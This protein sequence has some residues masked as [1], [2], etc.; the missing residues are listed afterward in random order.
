MG[1]SRAGRHLL[2]TPHAPDHYLRDQ[3]AC[4][5]EIRGNLSRAARGGLPPRNTVRSR[6]WEWRRSL[7]TFV[8][9]QAPRLSR[10]LVGIRTYLLVDCTICSVNHHFGC[11]FRSAKFFGGFN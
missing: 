11:A 9:V 1:G 8:T 10:L 4:F 2:R 5:R 3:T 7:N 6:S